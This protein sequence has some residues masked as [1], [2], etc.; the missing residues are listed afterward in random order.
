MSLKRKTIDFSYQLSGGTDSS[1][2]IDELGLSPNPPEPSAYDVAPRILTNRYPFHLNSH[3][4]PTEQ[5]KRRSNHLQDLS[6]YVHCD[7]HSTELSSA[8]TLTIEEMEMVD[9]E[10]LD[11]DDDS[12]S[13]DNGDDDGRHEVTYNK[14]IT[15]SQPSTRHRTPKL[16]L[17]TN[18]QHSAELMAA[19]LMASSITATPNS[20]HSH[21]LQP[22]SPNLID[23]GHRHRLRQRVLC[24]D[25][26][27]LAASFWAQHVHSLPL[28][29]RLEIGWALIGTAAPSKVDDERFHKMPSAAMQSLVLSVVDIMGWILRM[30]AVKEATL[31]A[32]LS[33]MGALYAESGIGQ[34]E[35]RRFRC[36]VHEVMAVHF[37]AEYTTAVQFAVD[38]I[39]V[40]SVQKMIGI[41][42]TIDGV[43]GKD[44]S[45]LLADRTFADLD[46]C[47]ASEIGREYLF[48]FLLQE[49]CAD[50]VLF[51]QLMCRY[52][53]ADDVSQ[54]LMLSVDI[55]ALCIDPQSAF[56]VKVLSTECRLKIAEKTNEYKR[57]SKMYQRNSVMMEMNH[58]E[59]M[60]DEVRR[61]I[62]SRYW[63]PFIRSLRAL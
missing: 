5:Q 43:A 58:F 7:P 47:M 17:D 60:E 37:N 30:M 32:S 33:K 35:Y 39:V 36:G 48:R 52:R 1:S 21:H 11:H 31:S 6:L 44:L 42:V 53:A 45:S 23:H 51:L 24:D 22:T 61:Y 13:Y 8:F 57:I 62:V 46:R 18:S 2:D 9:K 19:E 40:F 15:L 49:Q 56:S 38:Q 27:D 34:S 55:D 50:I 25:I 10:L 16:S 59:V 54:R 12:D 3:S 26:V 20:L 63:T 4:A 28:Q 14:P 41:D 29:Q